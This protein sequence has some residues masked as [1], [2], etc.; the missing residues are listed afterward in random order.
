VIRTARSLTIPRRRACTS[1]ADSRVTPMRRIRC[2]HHKA[3][4]I[5]DARTADSPR[6]GGPPGGR[7]D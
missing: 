7:F 4:L 6:L 3:G 5:A 1:Y 2:G